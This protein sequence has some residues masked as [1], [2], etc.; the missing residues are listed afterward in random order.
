[1]VTLNNVQL[2]VADVMG[3]PEA[4]V[5][6]LTRWI[7]AYANL[8]GKSR[9][10][11][12]IENVRMAMALEG[13]FPAFDVNRWFYTV[14]SLIFHELVGILKL[15][16]LTKNT[17]LLKKMSNNFAPETNSEA[18]RFGNRFDGI[19]FGRNRDSIIKQAAELLT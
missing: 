12:A 15:N 14:I 10:K 5:D 16:A 6:A 18:S 7:N 17:N 1:M 13:Y 4:E 8:L 2:T 9:D 19:N 11:E 3:W